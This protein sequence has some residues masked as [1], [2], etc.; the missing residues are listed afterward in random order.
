MAIAKAVSGQT[1]K[2]SRAPIFAK[3]S[4]RR[5]A[6]LVGIACLV[7]YWAASFALLNG[8]TVLALVNTWRD[9]HIGYRWALSPF[10]GI[11]RVAGFEIRHQDR[12]VQWVA[13][14]GSAWTGINL[15]ALGARRFHAF[16]V[17]GRDVEFRLRMV[18]SARAAKP[19]DATL[20][21][22]PGIPT[23]PPDDGKEGEKWGVEI[24]RV[25]LSRL[26]DA[27]VERLR[28]RGLS[29]VGGG[30]RVVPDT[31]V[32]VGPAV[33]RVE[34]GAI[35]IEGQAVVHRLGA[36]FQ[37]VLHPFHPDAP[38]NNEMKF[39]DVDGSGEADIE[40]LRFLNVFFRKAKW[41]RAERG[42]GTVRF[43]TAVRRG[44]IAPPSRISGQVSAVAFS[45][46]GSTVTGGARLEGAVKEGRGRGT[47]GTGA[48]RPF[49][50]LEVALEGFEA[51]HPADP[52]PHVKGET[53]GIRSRTE[54]LALVSAF[55]ELDL[56]LVVGKAR[57]PRLELYNRYL[58]RSSGVK[59]LSGAGKL[60]G[61]IWTSTRSGS[62]RG[63]LVISAENALVAHETT[64][65]KGDVRLVARL[66]RGDI[67]K[68]RFDVT[69]SE[70][71]LDD[72]AVAREGGAG[73][74]TPVAPWW[75]RVTVAR[76]VLQL[77]SPARA[78]AHLDVSC[79]D[80]RPFLALLSA[81]SEIPG[82]VQGA[83]G[84]NNLKA[85][86][87]LR[88]GDGL[89]DLREVDLRGGGLRVLARLR[90]LKWAKRAVLLLK[91]GPLAVGLERRGDESRIILH[92]AEAWYHGQAVR[93]P[94]VRRRAE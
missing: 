59:I 63:S 27:W 88:I 39:L 61:T 2:P 9:G 82:I 81:K 3:R 33:W 65:L 14:I 87:S 43:T 41:I 18:R 13:R 46:L 75:G 26:E 22:F 55:S 24:Q 8:G 70:L 42:K 12:N 4:V 54:A 48:A 10:P 52:E 69:G 89:V 6:A 57:M 77:G 40:S 58:P 64:R 66:A 49:A 35:A 7:A 56:E 79:R 36:D 38:D 62:D 17:R 45:L 31:E 1:E 5:W 47:S 80:A 86:L 73:R 85:S 67:E 60:E 20:P 21:P 44:I 72:V 30:F 90:F 53:L 28:F 16:F 94:E 83:L 93:F 51:R 32:R 25:S 92:R 50:S 34:S 68:T 19:G 84:R 15:F 71:R 37:V 11:V 74:G 23:K 78:R 91:Y 76:G 29:R